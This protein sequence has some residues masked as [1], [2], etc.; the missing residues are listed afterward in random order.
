[1]L[2]IMQV[3]WHNEPLGEVM[4]RLNTPMDYILAMKQMFCKAISKVTVTTSPSKSKHSRWQSDA[5]FAV[6][7]KAD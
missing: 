4:L 2:K 1:M 5:W 3:K 6:K 7:N